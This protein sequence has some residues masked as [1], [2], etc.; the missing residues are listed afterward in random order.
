MQSGIDLCHACVR[1][2]V[3]GGE[4]LLVVVNGLPRFEWNPVDSCR[5]PVL[6]KTAETIRI[7]KHNRASLARSLAGQ[8]FIEGS[9][10][11]EYDQRRC[12]GGL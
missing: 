9:K 11:Q 10:L 2:V 4:H 12:N 6:S 5:V 8:G 1:A 3:V 7:Y